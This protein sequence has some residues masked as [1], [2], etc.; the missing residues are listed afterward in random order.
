M[1][2]KQPAPTARLLLR[3]WCEADRVP[4]RAMN[5]DARVMACFPSTLTDAQSDALFDRI[6][7]HHAQHG[8]G[9]W[10]L[11]LRDTAATVD[12][13]IGFTGLSIPAWHPPFGPCVEVGWRLAHDHWGHGLATESARASLAYGFDVLQL[14]EIV[15]FTA[16]CNQRSER[17]MQRLGMRHDPADDFNH[18]ALPPGDRL[19]RHVLYRISR[20]AWA[21]LA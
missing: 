7:A 19:A 9:L 1:S 13:F 3:A 11:A 5:A 8:F 14:D 4:F 20:D 21:T 2:D 10:A 15:S 16:A 18:P 12:S 17:V 6:M